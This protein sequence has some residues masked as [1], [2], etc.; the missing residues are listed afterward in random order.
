MA[1]KPT[2]LAKLYLV[3][4]RIVRS[5]GTR[6]SFKA[7]RMVEL[8][9]GRELDRLN[10]RRSPAPTDRVQSGAAESSGN[11]SVDFV[12]SVNRHE[13]P[14]RGVWQNVRRWC[15][16]ALLRGGLCL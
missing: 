3:D 14:R 7:L 5:D 15:A 6:L 11:A 2:L 1:A 10:P 8:A 9:V 12:R 16:A 4:G 13:A